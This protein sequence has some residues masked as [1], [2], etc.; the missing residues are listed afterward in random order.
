MS[1]LTLVTIT[2]IVAILIYRYIAVRRLVTLNPSIETPHWQN[3]VPN[4]V[5]EYGL[6]R[7]WYVTY[8]N[9]QELDIVYGKY[10]YHNGRPYYE[11][12]GIGERDYQGLHK[13]FDAYGVY[14]YMSKDE[15]ESVMRKAVGYI[16]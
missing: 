14:P 8:P 15:V 10:I 13:Y 6:A 5:A 12:L 3:E 9:G 11:I 7:A 2:L 16:R 1:S 4:M